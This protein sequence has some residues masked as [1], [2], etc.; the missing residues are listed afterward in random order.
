MTNSYRCDTTGK[1]VKKVRE[2]KLE[3]L[4]R[5]RM[6]ATDFE[7]KPIV[8]CVT[9]L[10]EQKGVHLIKKH[11]DTRSKKAPTLSFSAPPRRS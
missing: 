11:V 6:D 5:M 4:K 10:T 2:A 8:A 7:S 9:R 3:L 1:H